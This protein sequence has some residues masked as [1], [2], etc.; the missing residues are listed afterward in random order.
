MISKLFING[1]KLRE[2]GEGYV[3]SLPAVRHLSQLSF[4]SPVSFLVGENG[5]GKSTLLEA[6]AVN[7]GFNPEGGSRDF[8][9][10]TSDTHSE[11][12]DHITVV[13]G[14]R[15]PTDG[16]F[17]R[18]ES[19]YNVASEVE[20]LAGSGLAGDSEAAMQSFYEGSYG[21]KSLH[22]QSH[23]ESFLSL[24]LH[25]FRGNGLYLLDEPEAALSPTRQMTLLARIHEMAKNGS[26]FIIA[27]HAP[28]LMSLPGADVFVLDEE[29][30]SCIPYK[31]TEH[32]AVTKLFLDDP[33]RMLHELLGE[34]D[35]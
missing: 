6:I 1:V 9:F 22:R 16:F 14:I 20:Q 10:S 21:G 12:A 30:I 29:G 32:Y 35:R 26:Q 31:E 4:S 5:T 23:G 18:A 13:K 24:V 34:P 17:L 28:I 33:D 2:R 11:L 3:F 15:R 25:R 7:S 27:T 19:F 8:R